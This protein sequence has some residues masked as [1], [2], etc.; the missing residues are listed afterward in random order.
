[1]SA[2]DI[3]VERDARG[4]WVAQTVNREPILAAVA[5]TPKRALKQLVKM[6]DEDQVFDE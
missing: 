3:R 2:I 4:G 1:M 5:D 6:L